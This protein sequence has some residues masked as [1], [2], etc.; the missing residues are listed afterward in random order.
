M[1]SGVFEDSVGD[2]PE[3]GEG[4][5]LRATILHLNIARVIARLS[6][7]VDGCGMRGL[8]KADAATAGQTKAS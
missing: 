8:V 2:K 5:S 6:L 4:A 1:R 7:C 3:S